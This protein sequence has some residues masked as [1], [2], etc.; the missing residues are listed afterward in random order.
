[1]TEFTEKALVLKTGRF[2][3]ADVW[4]RLFTPSRG[5]FTA[6]AF[7]GSRSR[8]RFCGCLDP[9]SES[10][11]TVKSDRG[12]RYLTLQ[13]GTLLRSFP[14]LRRDL[15]RLGHAVNCL[16][17][18]EA[19]QLGP[20]GAQ[21]THALLLETLTL[22]DG[23]EGAPVLTEEA[24]ELLP[25]FFRA[26]TTFA[27]GLAPELAACHDCGRA[28]QG[29]EGFS[30][31]VEAGRLCCRPCAGHG[32]ETPLPMGSEAVE[33]LAFV[34]SAPPA[35]WPALTLT[36]QARREIYLFVER[37]VRCHLGLTWD[38]GRVERV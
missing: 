34:S 16:K 3:E 24:L 13:E 35:A 4:V 1:M 27:Q 20:Q 19:I 8:R 11:V 32:P 2:R 15:R 17:F 9:L 29:A 7:G 10:L 33:A 12:G 25:L 38:N 21:Q 14:G 37:F 26:R 18:L 5:A 36:R 22:L 28:V 6:F 23:E 30:F 31:L